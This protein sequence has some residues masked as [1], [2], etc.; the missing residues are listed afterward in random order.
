MKEKRLFTPGPLSVSRRVKEAMLRDMGSRDPEFLRIVREIRSELLHLAGVE[1]TDFAAV[2]MQGSGSFGLEA[3]L[4]TAIPRSGHLLALVN[5]AYGRRLVQMARILE[6]PTTV[7][8]VPEDQTFEAED[9]R[10]IL[11]QTPG[12]THAALCHCET[13]SGIRNPVEIV[14]P[15][16]KAA[17][18]DLIVDA[19]SSFGCLPIDL[20]ESGVDY[21]VSSPNKCLQGVPGF[22]FVLARRTKLD[23]TEGKAKSLALDL[24]AQER[25]L[26][27]T[28]QFR[29]T[30]PTHALLAFYE[31]LQELRDEGGFVAR[32][33]RYRENHRRL[34][35]GMIDLG[36]RPFLPKSL[37]SEIITS[38]FIPDHPDFSFEGF[39]Q[40][41][42]ER[43]C[44]IYPGKVG[45]AP[46]FRIGTIG[47]LFPSD[48]DELL[49]AIKELAPP[50]SPR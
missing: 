37:Q 31:A 33:A 32:S 22:C 42:S 14:A 13:T 9:V 12:V 26:R 41:L 28:G 17:G 7:L 45:K 43:G 16:L 27:D 40:A 38:F 36:F 24:G 46:C 35:E 18:C 3:V 21:L 2:L 15:I 4:A 20:Q 6:I 5:G 10:A 49:A 30:P 34:L 1:E 19:M 11:S 48:V 47:D 8:E 44:L 25:F 29:F 23:A 50:L 39:Y